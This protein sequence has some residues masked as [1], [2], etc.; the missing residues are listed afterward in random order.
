MSAFSSAPMRTS[1][2]RAPWG[3]ALALCA[4]VVIG[5]L[6]YFLDDNTEAPSLIDFDIFRIAGR[7]AVEGHLADAYDWSRLRDL[8]IALGGKPTG[9][10]PFAYPPPFALAMAGLAHL[11]TGAAYFG[12]VTLGLGLIAAALRRLAPTAF[13]PC[14]AALVPA[15]CINIAIGQNG[16][17]T[18][19][20]AGLAT[21]WALERR[22]PAAGGV[23]GLLAALKPQVAVVLP[24]MLVLR[25]QGRALVAMAAAGSALAGL[26]VLCFGPGIVGI[27]LGGLA[28]TGEAL[29]AGRFPLHRMTSVYAGLRAL[30][31]PSGVALGSH[32]AAAALLLAAA[33]LVGRRAGGGRAEAGLLLMTTAFV[34]PYFYDYDLP[35]VGA[36]LALVLGATTGPRKLVALSLAG[37]AGAGAAGMIEVMATDGYRP[38]LGALFV[39]LS[40]GSA[41]QLVRR[42][43]TPASEARA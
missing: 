28:G 11:S 33:I 37:L 12:F 2:R 6:A 24:L 22:G 7:L 19:G 25:G 23:A 21:A 4:L 30:G 8:E 42:H 41:L 9:F 43:A 39:L 16:M 18:G 34:S 27:F 36:G 26:A 10:G 3:P 32:L 29:A 5:R 38:S 15:V 31:L 1:P 14:F 35:V 20:L 13:W 17:L 40:F